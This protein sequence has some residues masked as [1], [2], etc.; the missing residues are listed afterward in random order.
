MNY[1][2]FS[3]F[4]TYVKF[5]DRQESSNLTLYPNPV[6]D[7]LQ[8]SYEMVKAGN[9]QVAII[10]IQGKVLH[11]QT[12]NSQNGTNHA[13]ISVSHLPEGLYVCRLQKGGKLETIKFIKN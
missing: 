5:I 1:L 4:T 2:I 13:I 6:I 10:D 7:Q 12:I 3:D 9:V 8:I 11:Q